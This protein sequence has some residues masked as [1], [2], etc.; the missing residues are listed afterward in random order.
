MKK[1]II[2]IGISLISALFFT[3]NCAKEEVSPVNE[4][5]RSEAVSFK[6]NVSAQET[7][8]TTEDGATIKWD[9]GDAINVFHAVTGSTEYGSNDK[10]T[11]AEGTTFNGE[12]KD[13][14][15]DE[16][17]TYDWYVMYPY[18]SRIKTPANT[19]AGFTTVGS[20]ASGSQTQDGNDDKAHLAGTSIPL[21]GK[22]TGVAATETPSITLKQAVAVVKVHVT[23]SSDE[24]LTVSDVAFTGTEDIVGTYYIDFSGDA[25]VFKGSGDKY[26][27][28]VA[29]L[30]VNSG[31]AIEINGSAEF[32]IAVKPFTANGTLKVAVNGYEK[33]YPVTNKTFSAG[34]IKTVNFSYDRI[35]TAKLNF[36]ISG[37]GGFAAYSSVAGMSSSG[38]EEDYAASNSPYLAKFDNT[39]DYVQVRFNE[40][41]GKATIGVKM[42]AGAT[43]SY[44]DVMGSVD[45]T[46]C[47]LIQKLTV[48]GAQNATL[49]LSTTE[50][51]SETYRYI[52]FIFEKGDNVAVGPISI[53]KPSTDPEII[54]ENIANIPATGVIDATTTYSLK[55]FTGEDDITVVPDGTI[56][57]HATVDHNTKKITYDV[58]PNYD[59]KA[60]SGTIT[61]RSD[62]ED[63]TKEIKV[64]QLKSD[65]KVN[66]ETKNITIT[67]PYDSKSVTFTVTSAEFD[68]EAIPYWSDDN[69]EFYVSPENG[70][71]NVD[72]QTL[73]VTS[74]VE[75]TNAEQTLGWIEVFRNDSTD[76]QLRK[77][78]IKKA[79]EPSTSLLYSATFEGDN[80]HRTSGNNSYS[81]TGNSYTVSGT[82]WQFVYGDVATT[83]TPLD[84]SAN[85]VMRI[86]KNTTNN[87]T[88]T[89]GNLLSSS[90]SVKKISFLCKSVN[91]ITL[92]VQ[93][94]TD[95]GKTWNTVNTVTKD[96][97]VNSSYGYSAT[98]ENVENVSDFRLKFSWTVTSATKSDRDSQLDNICI[99][100][101]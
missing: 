34:K 73:T 95:G 51:I 24:P 33:E 76:P 75:P 11:L 90:N 8:T 37:E 69:I 40:A 91:S 97:S 2:T 30:T 82:S 58:N 25:P 39:G 77:V 84:G 96:T 26:V 92:A 9:T 31:T 19:S 98:I 21:Y 70:E 41:A 79:A 16:S 59:Y 29:K 55:N 94:S 32:Y 99:Y 5:T 42:I 81:S 28:K 80:E 3:T 45:G 12:L 17:K 93:Y 18:D 23:N 15:L 38:V 78:T 74:E 13:G 53:S 35:S 4:E 67:I 61:L 64:F 7:R 1:N 83:G 72:A 89:S 65:L 43:T 71:A 100:S 49:T 88:A 22:T 63:I 14:A 6:L 44:F 87:P 85:A 47:T 86:A 56:V 50:D 66:D 68:W 27:S 60:K 46:A 57:T 48:A 101:E 54:A 36:E 10:F 62:S 20:S 52:R